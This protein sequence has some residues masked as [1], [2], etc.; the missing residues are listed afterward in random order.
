MHSLL[1]LI[2]IRPHLLLDHAEAYADLLTEEIGRVSNAWKLRTLLY[3]MALC[4]L[5]LATVL[6]GT[7][8]MFW[9]VTPPL[10][11]RAL[12][13]L[14]CVPLFPIFGAIWCLIAARG[15]TNNGFHNLREQIQA[16]MGMLRD[17]SAP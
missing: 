16:D 9:A 1:R 2:A 17:V 8:L 4:G 3:A 7:A 5:L 6:G 10:E 14:V 11:M 13:V 15:Q 12:W